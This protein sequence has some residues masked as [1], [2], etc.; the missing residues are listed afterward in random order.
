MKP[1]ATAKNTTVIPIIN[2]S[3]MCRSFRDA[4]GERRRGGVRAA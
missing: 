3:S 2:T 1:N 4:G